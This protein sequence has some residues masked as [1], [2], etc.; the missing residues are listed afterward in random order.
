MPA[1]SRHHFHRYRQIVTVLAKNGFGLLFEQAGVFRLLR[2]R[3]RDVEPPSRHDG[4]HP[5][6][7]AGVRLRH[8]CE[9]LGPTFVK[10]GQLLSTRPDLLPGDIIFELEKL[11]ESVQPISYQDVEQVIEA[12]FGKPINQV[13]PVFD[14]EPLAS[15]SISQVHAAVLDSGFAVAV[16]VQRPDIEESIRI[17]LEIL[18]DLAG[19]LD[20][21]THYGETYDLTS[22]VAELDIALT[23]ELD[24]IQE[25]ENADRFRR[26]F[27]DSPDVHFPVIRWVYTTRRVLTMERI[28]GFRISQT[29]LLKEAG[30]DCKELGLILSETMVNQMLRD[31]FFH[32]DPH[33]GNLLIQPEGTI[34]IIDL[35]QVG[36]LNAARKQILTDLF[37][38]MAN[39]D[40]GKVVEA[41]IA[42]D[43]MKQ[44][45]QLRQFEH[46]INNLLEQY[47]DM[48]IH[49]IKVG[50]LLF[51][52]FELARKYHVRI[53]G[54]F[55]LM[56]KMLVTLQGI[57]EKLDETL[58][59]LTIM[60]PMAKKLMREQFNPRESIR[61]LS[62]SASAYEHLLTE[63]PEGILNFLRKLEDD[64]YTIY[65]DLKNRR[66]LHHQVNQIFNRLAFSI[67][68]LAVS[69]VLAGIII[70]SS[71]I[72]EADAASFLMNQVVLRIGLLLC[73]VIIIGLIIS[74]F[75]GR[76]PK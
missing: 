17:D 45:S 14:R 12:E 46:D 74:M 22:M 32:A 34:N 73:L 61:K 72:A 51:K 39:R 13:F 43:T 62:R 44:R 64:D 66:H 23:H 8:A 70:G 59:L 37:I 6:L 41:I 36:R 3:R 69:I 54:D 15:A 20:R 18:K 19:L 4:P 2:L 38:G 50:D 29:D 28:T 71:L 63:A 10:I 30:I 57:V 26:N 58:D 9:T 55:A 24:F 48:P 31:G 25:G 47:L 68:L 21:H 49:D 1:V 27:A 65:L 5:P 75:R 53:P 11:Q 42:L 67:I 56:A 76:K 16:K 60:K 7:T 35:G 33:P 52:I 40:G